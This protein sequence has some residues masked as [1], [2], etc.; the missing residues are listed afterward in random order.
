MFTFIFIYLS[1]INN[2]MK[3]K[4]SPFIFSTRK[5]FYFYFNILLNI[6]KQT[7][8]G[9]K[10]SNTLFLAIWENVIFFP[11]VMVSKN[12]SLKVR[13]NQIIIVALNLGDTL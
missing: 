5:Y 7:Q 12:V 6:Y 2:T 13:A 9:H 3:L 8:I 4:Y 11:M 10:Y 1:S